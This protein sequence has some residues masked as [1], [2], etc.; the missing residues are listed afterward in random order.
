[1]AI[2][3]AFAQALSSPQTAAAGSVLP[4]PGRPAASGAARMLD[5]AAFPKLT[6][7]PSRGRSGMS[8]GRRSKRSAQ[9]RTSRNAHQASA[10][11]TLLVAGSCAMFHLY[12]VKQKNGAGGIR[13]PVPKQSASRVYTCSRLR[14]SRLDE[15]RATA[16]HFAMTDCFLVPPPPVR[17]LEPA[18][19][20]RSTPH[21]ASGADRAGL[22]RQQVQTAVRQ[23]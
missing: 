11:K 23:L 6:T 12:A 21:R 4:I 2:L 10:H 1:M 13:T 22:F 3:C 5:E 14:F 17:A 19:C 16:S 7:E 15:R 8:C 18:R 9:K 20:P